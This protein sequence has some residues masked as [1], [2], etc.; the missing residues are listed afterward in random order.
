MVPPPIVSIV[1]G[2]VLSTRGVNA[3]PGVDWG[4]DLSTHRSGVRFPAR[5][6]TGPPLDDLRVLPCDQK[7]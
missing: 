3:N 5:R 4:I 1:T 7:V 6:I 2:M